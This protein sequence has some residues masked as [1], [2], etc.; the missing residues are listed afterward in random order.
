MIVQFRSWY[1]ARSVREQR[2]LQLMTAI[3]IPLL[4]W[5]LLVRPLSNAYDKAVQSHLQAV[6]RNGRVKAL[7]ER[8]SG[9]KA[10]A[11]APVPDLPLFLSDR[12]RQRG[13]AAEGRPGS[14]PGSAVISIASSSAP[15]AFEWLRGL[16][17]DGYRLND[18]RVAPT[19]GGAVS[20][21]ATVYGPAR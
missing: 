21:T 7:A 13:I 14:A 1:G 8:A 18:V 15:S 20:V 5:L 6:D 19:G 2:L 16:E 10:N 3:A 4:I 12:A 9:G 17:A 11:P